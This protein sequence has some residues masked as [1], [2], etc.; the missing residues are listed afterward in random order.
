MMNAEDLAPEK[1]PNRF[2]AVRMNAIV[3]NEFTRAVVYA[4]NVKFAVEPK[5]R[6]VV[7]SQQG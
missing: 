4:V 2:N 6:A 5:K 3:P 1:R 7:V